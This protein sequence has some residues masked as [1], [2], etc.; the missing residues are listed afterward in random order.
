MTVKKKG[1]SKAATKKPKAGTVTVE[2]L[3]HELDVIQQILA[4]L[5]KGCT[6]T[7]HARVVRYLAHRA[8]V[9]AEPIR[10]GEKVWKVVCGLSEEIP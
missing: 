2:Q 1:K 10:V 6:D 7:Q 3:D 5:N 8:G 4:I 9:L